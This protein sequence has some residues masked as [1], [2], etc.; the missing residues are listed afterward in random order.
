[1]TSK[2]A[3]E[4]HP[5]QWW[6]W[7]PGSRLTAAPRNDA[8][9][10]APQEVQRYCEQKSAE[11]DFE[12]APRQPMREMRAVRRDVARDRSGHH[13][14]NQRNKAQRER[15]QLGLVRQAGKRKTD[16]AGNRDRH[17]DARRR[18]DRIVDWLAIDR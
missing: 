8:S 6:I 11:R 1:M 9:K 18:G 17:G 13:K 5:D 12:R 4:F 15:R 14:S 2:A 16:G 7:I 3:H 10:Q